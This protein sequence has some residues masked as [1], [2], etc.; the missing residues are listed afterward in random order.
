MLEIEPNNLSPADIILSRSAGGGSVGWVVSGEGG[1]ERKGGG[2]GHGGGGMEKGSVKWDLRGEGS[3]CRGG[4]GEDDGGR[5]GNVFSSWPTLDGDEGE[6][7]SCD[8][9]HTQRSRSRKFLFH[10]PR[11]KTSD[12]MECASAS[13]TV[14]S[15]CKKCSGRR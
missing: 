2:N 5:G 3:G 9:K 13:V 15:I 4:G 1:G 6:G 11:I 12:H 7:V 8:N 14:L 10:L